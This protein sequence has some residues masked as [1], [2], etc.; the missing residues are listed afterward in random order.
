MPGGAKKPDGSDNSVY[1]TQP[2][3]YVNLNEEGFCLYNEMIT[4]Q[5]DI[6]SFESKLKYDT[7]LKYCTDIIQEK[8]S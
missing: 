2:D 3:I 1:G 8:L 7:V 6:S 5:N 4:S